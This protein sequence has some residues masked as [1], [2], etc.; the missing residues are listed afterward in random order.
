MWAWNGNNFAKKQTIQ[1]HIVAVR[2]RENNLRGKLVTLENG[3]HITNPYWSPRVRGTLFENFVVWTSTPD[4][5]QMTC[6]H[7]GQCLSVQPWPLLLWDRAAPSST[8]SFIES[9]SVLWSC[10]S[11]GANWRHLLLES[12][13]VSPS[14]PPHTHEGIGDFTQTV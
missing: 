9:D 7:A 10:K 14:L 4:L 3:V 6:Y 5:M 11:P 13:S 2:K 1:H 8:S 12:S